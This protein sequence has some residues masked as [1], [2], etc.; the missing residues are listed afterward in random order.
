MSPTSV[1]Y[2]PAAVLQALV[3]IVWSFATILGEECGQHPVITQLFLNSRKEAI[4]RCA[5]HKAS[6]FDRP[7]DR[8]AKGA[9]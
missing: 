1:C 3:N 6:P 4:I 5:L 2:V 8:L 9:G 7:T